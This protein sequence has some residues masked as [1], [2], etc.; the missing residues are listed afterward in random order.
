[1]PAERTRLSELNRTTHAA[2]W[3][4]CG[5]GSVDL[6]KAMSCL[7]EGQFFAERLCNDYLLYRHSPGFAGATCSSSSRR[8]TS[9]KSLFCVQL[10]QLTTAL[11]VLELL[12]GKPDSKPAATAVN[13]LVGLVGDTPLTRIASLSEAT[14]CE[15]QAVLN[16]QL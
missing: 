2:V 3:G 4:L 6:G 12:C 10:A 11:Q 14:G 9:Q 7:W 13:G 8:Y 1:M 15:V 16:G 5:P